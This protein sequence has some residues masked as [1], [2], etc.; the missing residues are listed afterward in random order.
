MR[1]HAHPLQIN[2]SQVNYSI[3]APSPMTMESIVSDQFHPPWPC[4]TAHG[5]CVLLRFYPQLLNPHAVPIMDSATTREQMPGAVPDTDYE[6]PDNE[7][8]S[9]FF[10]RYA[11]SIQYVSPYTTTSLPGSFGL[12]SNGSTCTHRSPLAAKSQP[13]L[14][15][16]AEHDPSS[17]TQGIT[18]Y[19]DMSVFARLTRLAN[20]QHG[21]IPAGQGY[22][23]QNV[24]SPNLTLNNTRVFQSTMPRRSRA[25]SKQ[26]AGINRP[27]RSLRPK[28]HDGR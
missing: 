15:P 27:H 22:T 13:S 17:L 11:G 16:S 2:A 24:L 12:D 9:A 20:T 19:R 18:L 23:K 21:T 7:A 1:S 26:S 14:F 8:L 5:P 6:Y 3:P 25:V 28:P 4:N 10:S